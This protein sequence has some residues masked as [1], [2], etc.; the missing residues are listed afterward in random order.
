MTDRRI[1]IILLAGTAASIGVLWTSAI[2]LGVP[3]EWVWSRIP[4]PETWSLDVILGWGLGGLAAAGYIGIAALGAKRLQACS[5]FEAAGWLCA[6]VAAGF[7][8]LTAAQDSAPSP[9]GRKKS[10]W[11]LYFRGPSGYYREARY[12]MPEV[13]I[14]IEEYEDKMREGDVLH[15]GTHPPGLFLMHKAF[16]QLCERFPALT[17]FL[18]E[19]R[20][21]TV[22]N[23]MGVIE[24]APQGTATPVF[25]V[26]HAALWLAIIVTQLAAVLTV[27]PLYLLLRRDYSAHISWMT[28]AFW[29]LLPSLALFLPKSDALYPLLGM[30][31]LASWLIGRQRQSIS[32]CVLSGVALWL[33]MFLSLAILPYVL[34]AFIL[35]VWE[36]LTSSPDDN[37]Q[38]RLGKTVALSCAVAA[39]FVGATMTLW[40]LFELNLVTIWRWNLHN[41]AGFY[42]EYTRTYWKW[43][44]VNPVELMLATGVPVVLLTMIAYS[45]TLPNATAWKQKSLGPYVGCAAVWGLLWL[46]GKNMGEAARL[47]INFQP[48]LIWLLA[49]SLVNPTDE[50]SGQLTKPT[51]RTWLLAL[52]LACIVCLATVVRVTG[53][54]F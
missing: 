19:T 50:T 25:R 16:I 6:L 13:D 9:H 41:H 53:F 12:A 21:H 34:L 3:G 38:P 17:T 1:Q 24:D 10:P 52:A 27:I 15:I 32:L 28:V 51:P 11:V 44:L 46:S 48:W 23:G 49:A 4:L 40:W 26:D 47:W 37:D 8:W 30:T 14:F 39:P 45:R 35:T 7:L 54:D 2:P 5:R 22:E 18:M 43:L 31:F 36:L 20:P 33:A 29:P 42:D